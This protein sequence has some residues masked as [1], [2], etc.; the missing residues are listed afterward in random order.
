M[1]DTLRASCTGAEIKL[2][3]CP[4][5]AYR[6]TMKILG[7]DFTSRPSWRKPI[8]CIDCTLHDDAL[9]THS[10]EEWPSYES[11]ETALAKPGPWEAVQRT[12]RRATSRAA[13]LPQS[14]ALA[15]SAV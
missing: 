2:E 11:F 5:L 3:L 13:P 12:A 14:S 4:Y 15:R 10:F 8:T 6:S 9:R 1:L 7:I